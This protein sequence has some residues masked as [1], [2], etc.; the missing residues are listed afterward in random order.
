MKM[1]VVDI[2][3]VSRA[4]KGIKKVDKLGVVDVISISHTSKSSSAEVPD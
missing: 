4:H 1:G 2:V 3:S